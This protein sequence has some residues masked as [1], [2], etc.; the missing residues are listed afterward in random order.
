MRTLI[1]G[2]GTVGREVATRLEARDETVV[3]VEQN[4]AIVERARQAGHTVHVGD[5]TDTGVLRS[6]GAEDARTVIAGTSDDDVNLLIAQLTNAGFDVARVI[7]RVNNPDNVEAFED[8]GVETI[9]PTR[10]TAWGIDN[11]I[12]RPAL[13]RW[14]NEL[15]QSGEVL[16]IEVT[17]EDLIGRSIAS[18]KDDLPGGSLIALVD[19][20]SDQR[21]P[22]EDFV[23]QR[24]D[25]V[26]IIG[27]NEA[28]DSALDRLGS[29][30]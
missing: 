11:L 15:G 27:R 29:D 8:L 18:I 5:G 3:I 10:A 24:G 7:A 13:A 17:A 21:V 12:E 1:V 9:S 23:V 30:E 4:E 14:M 6:A 28:V 16:E 25:T 19:R 20:D 22:D 26:T 2:G